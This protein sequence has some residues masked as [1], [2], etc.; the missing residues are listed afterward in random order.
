MFF[1]DEQSA[2]CRVQTA[3]LATAQAALYHDNRHRVSA[4]TH[5]LAALHELDRHKLAGRFLPAQ[6]HEPERAAVKVFDLRSGFESARGGEREAS[7][8]RARQGPWPSPRR[9]VRP[10]IAPTFSYLGW[11]ARGSGLPPGRD[12]AGASPL[13]RGVAC[14]R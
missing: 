12:M 9:G 3:E 13:I 2:E 6:L 14:R 7:G 5:L 11:P 1:R 4:T 8:T 10:S